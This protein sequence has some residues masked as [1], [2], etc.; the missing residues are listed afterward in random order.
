MSQHN[1]LIR[2]R[3]NEI[4]ASLMI[5]TLLSGSLVGC[6]NNEQLIQGVKEFPPNDKQANQPVKA[7]F[8]KTV[9]ECK[10]D[11]A[12]KRRSYKKDLD[13]Y[14]AGVLKQKPTIILLRPEECEAQIAL[15]KMEYESNSPVYNTLQ[16]CQAE[17]VLCRSF[18]NESNTTL[19]TPR[20]GGTFIY[21]YSSTPDFVDFYYRDSNYRLYRP[22][23]VFEGRSN[24]LV[25]PY[26]RV[27]PNYQPGKSVTVPQHTRFTAPARP[28]STA[29]TGIIKGRSVNGF[30]STYK[31]TG[32]GGIGK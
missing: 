14:R 7:I 31:R 10:Q 24:T 11:I 2:I 19:Y 8:Y 26:G 18:I 12:E 1:A 22:S 15:A 23:T 28:D 13:N 30:G 9:E 16:A 17:G 21:P 32:A 4:I 6:F 5:P 25:T 20:F 27:L 29:G 3:R